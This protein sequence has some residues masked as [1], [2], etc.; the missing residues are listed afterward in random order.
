MPLQEIHVHVHLHG[1]P[2]SGDFEQLKTMIMANF[3][4]LKTEFNAL[5]EAVTEERARIAAKIDELSA[6][7]TELET[8]INDGGTVEERT[9]LLDDMRSLTAEVKSI[10]PDAEPEA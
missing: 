2:T 3:E 7:I 4:E 8:N 6:K 5:K 10:I 1:M 9:Q